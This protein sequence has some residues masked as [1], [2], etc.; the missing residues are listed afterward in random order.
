MKRLLPLFLCLL[1]VGPASAHS[2]RA[3]QILIGHP[4]VQPTPT[5]TTEL[6]LSLLNRSQTADQLVGVIAPLARSAELVDET[7]SRIALLDLPPGRPLALKPGG[8]RIRL[9][10]LDRPLPMGAKLKLTLVFAKA[11]SVAI[12][13]EA[14]AGPSHG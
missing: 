8:K 11:G 1:L 3:G 10:D 9:V 4:W 6:Y 13:A 2:F 12:E 5:R 14:E 7:G